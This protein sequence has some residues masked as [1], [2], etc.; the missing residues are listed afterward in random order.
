MTP[1]LKP[2]P[3]RFPSAFLACLLA[4]PALA[5][6]QEGVRTVPTPVVAALKVQLN[7]VIP[8]YFN[9][10]DRSAP[11]MQ[12]F[13]TNLTTLLARPG[14]T[15]AEN[16]AAQMLALSLRN[17]SLSAAAVDSVRSAS[18]PENRKL[19]VE[20][21][22]QLDRISRIVN[23]RLQ[24][25]PEDRQAFDRSLDALG[26]RL[27]GLQSAVGSP[28][29]DEAAAALAALFGEQYRGGPDAA[30]VRADGGGT[31]A[32][33]VRLGRSTPGAQ[34]AAAPRVPSPEAFSANGGVWGRGLAGARQLLNRGRK[35]LEA[36]RLRRAETARLK[37]EEE[38]ARLKEA[39]TVRHIESVEEAL[40]AAPPGNQRVV[41]AEIMERSGLASSAIKTALATIPRRKWKENKLLVA[42]VL[43][44][45]SVTQEKVSEAEKT[46]PKGLWP[47]QRGA[48][49]AIMAASG[50]E[51]WA[52]VAASEKLIPPGQWAND[53]QRIVIAAL[54]EGFGAGHITYESVLAAE[55]LIPPGLWPKDRAVLAAH[56]AYFSDQGRDIGLAPE[57][58]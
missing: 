30:A 57:D 52:E 35:A 31:A 50:D 19:G 6:I 22:Q 25:N 39:I 33:N 26:S 10:D 54:K 7:A 49:A 53:G 51:T 16:G 23:A 40:R 13:S 32:D 8:M 43:A 4:A 2:G 29:G 46:I 11:S 55:R 38:T 56:I 28:A 37:D 17:P 48:V 1:H 41:V 15:G 12:L 21:A 3:Y 44:A 36:F 58:R 42:T 5:A 27:R 47:T 14:M 45:A 18:T 20:A 24:N 34:R 9:S